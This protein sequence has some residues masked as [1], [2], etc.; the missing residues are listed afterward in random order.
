MARCTS[1]GAELPDYYTS[2]PNCGGQV[3]QNAPAQAPV[4]QGQYYAPAPEQRVITSIGGWFG[5]TLLCGFLPIIGAI[6]MLNCSKDQTAKNFAKLM[7][8]MQAIGFVLGLLFSSILVPSMLNYIERV[9]G[10]GSYLTGF[11]PF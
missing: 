9:G 5:W 10:Y 8:I 3:S 7:I 1:C 6:I 11:L 2:C 4:M